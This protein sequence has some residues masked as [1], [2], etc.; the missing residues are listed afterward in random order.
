VP[1]RHAADEIV[2][3]DAAAPRRLP[4]R[5]AVERPVT[6]V[7]PRP[8]PA[9]AEKST[10]PQVQLT[11]QRPEPARTVA[12]RPAT[13]ASVAPEPAVPQPVTIR[14][15]RVEVRAV[16]AAAPPAPASARPRPRVSLDEFLGRRSGARRE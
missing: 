15:D 8:A 5:E 1:A 2:H 11:P 10:P 3:E 14:I 16:P 7:E 9:K 12:T 13:M 6:V 4:T